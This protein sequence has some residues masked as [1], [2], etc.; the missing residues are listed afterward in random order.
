[1]LLNWVR[2][3]NLIK[4]GRV[5]YVSIFLAVLFNSVPLLF[6]NLKELAK[7]IIKHIWKE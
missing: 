5:G 3:I 2:T 6:F 4:S 1:M 7:I